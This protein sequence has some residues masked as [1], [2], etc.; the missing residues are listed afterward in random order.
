MSFSSGFRESGKQAQEGAAK[1]SIGGPY[2]MAGGALTEGVS[3]LIEGW[4]GKNDVTKGIV[5]SQNPGRV[6]E[7][8]WNWISG[9]DD[10][11]GDMADPVLTEEQKQIYALLYPDLAGQYGAPSQL[12]YNLGGLAEGYGAYPEYVQNLA[13]SYMLP[14]MN[15]TIDPQMTEFNT[16]LAGYLSGFMAPTDQTQ[17]GTYSKD[18]YGKL[19]GADIYSNPQ[20]IA[21]EKYLRDKGARS[22]E[23]TL[24]GFASI[25][26][27]IPTNAIQSVLSRT[28]GEIAG[29][30][31]QPM[32]GWQTANNQL[33]GNMAGMIDELQARVAMGDRDA[34]NQLA[35]IQ[36][37]LMKSG[38]ETDL[39]TDLANR[40]FGFNA[41]SNL[42][43]LLGGS[44][45]QSLQGLGGLYDAEQTQKNNLLSGL[46]SLY[47]SGF[48]ASQ[49]GLTQQQIN[50]QQQQNWL[51]QLQQGAGTGVQAYKL[52]NSGG[53]T[54][55]PTD[56]SVNTEGLMN[57]G[58]NQDYSLMNN[59][60]DLGY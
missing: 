53:N 9:G 55:T 18:L 37:N 42:T 8:F 39:S 22:A 5:Y 25:S 38:A 28:E 44:Q 57:Y 19:S 58:N 46:M 59:N 49:L 11:G 14:Y 24:Q 20:M 1:G 31:A 47:G 34:I 45:M 50:N 16:D 32:I 27:A 33:L 4:G 3:G 6:L 43:N 52:W 2:G 23:N 36:T 51:N 54:Y 21:L 10:N 13:D 15:Q 17:L 40:E 7:D 29:N 56:Y 60:Y 41:G 12:G 26:S 35:I 30:L 48:N